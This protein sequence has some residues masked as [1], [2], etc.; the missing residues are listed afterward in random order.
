MDRCEPRDCKHRNPITPMTHFCFQPFRRY[1]LPPQF[2]C[3]FFQNTPTW[4]TGYR[5]YIDHSKVDVAWTLSFKSLSLS[6]YI[7]IHF[8]PH[9]LINLFFPFRLASILLSRL[10][11]SL[12]FRYLSRDII[13]RTDA[14]SDFSRFRV[15]SPPI[16]ICVLKKVDRFFLFST[17]CVIWENRHFPFYFFLLTRRRRDLLW[18][19]RNDP[20]LF[21][22][23]HS[24]WA[25]GRL[26]LRHGLHRS[27]PLRWWRRWLLFARSSRYSLND[28]QQHPSSS[29]LRQRDRVHRQEPSAW[30][31][32]P[33]NTVRQSSRRHSDTRVPETFPTT[34]SV[35]STL[36][37]S[38][39]CR[40]YEYCKS[41]SNVQSVRII[42][43]STLFISR[44]LSWRGFD[45][46][47]FVSFQQK[48][49]CKSGE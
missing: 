41:C 17:L 1:C 12:R 46:K 20:L 34:S 39:I 16:C 19:C 30:I 14:K 2:H 43:N 27:L 42:I 18:P 32:L 36:T 13:S 48:F 31:L 38:R 7:L 21:I 22:R 49:L 28:S 47:C 11:L 40:I 15:L 35:T 23:A 4:R 33:A 3:E 9:S 5:K 24:L 29:S 45:R 25:L 10:G 6:L 26:L 8:E 37:S 44:F